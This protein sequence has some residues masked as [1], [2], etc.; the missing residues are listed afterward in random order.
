MKVAITFT[1][2]EMAFVIQALELTSKHETDTFK[3]MRQNE[4]ID[5]LNK[6]DSITDYE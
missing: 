3:K 1:E 5:K 4:L 2:D 6:I